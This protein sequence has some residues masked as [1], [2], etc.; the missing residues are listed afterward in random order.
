MLEEPGRGRN[1]NLLELALPTIHI[2]SDTIGKQLVAKTREEHFRGDVVGSGD[3]DGSPSWI[4]WTQLEG[5]SDGR[6]G[7]GTE[8]QTGHG[9][10]GGGGDGRVEDANCGSAES[11]LGIRGKEKEI[12]K[13]LAADVELLM[14]MLRLKWK[15][16][17]GGISIATNSL[18]G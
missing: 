12:A 10:G 9:G 5:G 7:R 11:P 3:G 15:E 17:A 4:C 2:P 6:A 14:P 18:R 1:T 13:G 8:R 16:I